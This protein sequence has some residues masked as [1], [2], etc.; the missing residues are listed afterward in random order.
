MVEER[1][2]GSMYITYKD[3]DL[4]Y[5]E[6]ARRAVRVVDLPK[7]KIGIRKR[8]KP[9]PDHPWYKFKINKKGEREIQTVP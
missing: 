7:P 2:D 4:R 1:T 8:R 9:S 3:K 6:I 5:K